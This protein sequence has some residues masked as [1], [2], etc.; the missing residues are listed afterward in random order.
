MTLDPILCGMGMGWTSTPEQLALA[1]FLEIAR[2]GSGV[3]T[4]Q[5]LPRLIPNDIGIIVGRPSS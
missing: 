1:E 3:V 5:P 4:D 2:R